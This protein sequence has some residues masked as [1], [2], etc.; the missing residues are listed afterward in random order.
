M[1]AELPADWTELPLAEMCARVSVGYVGETSS[2]Y[3]D[4]TG[5]ALIR[6]QNVRPNRLDLSDVKQVTREFHERSKKSQLVAGDLLI[7]RVR[8]VSM[9]LRHPGTLI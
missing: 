6:S 9:T 1:S 7:V 5:I 4:G 3:T 2:H 8:N